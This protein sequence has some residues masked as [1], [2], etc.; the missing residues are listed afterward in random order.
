MPRLCI[1]YP[2]ICLTT[3]ENQE[4]VIAGVVSYI[5]LCWGRGGFCGIGQSG[6][7]LFFGTSCSRR[8]VCLPP[9][10]YHVCVGLVHLVFYGRENKCV[11][12]RKG[13]F[14]IVCL[15]FLCI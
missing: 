14:C 15:C 11:E 9:G 8:G 7:S 13:R 1:E 3:E 12:C 10:F 4:T 2:A 5:L 6:I